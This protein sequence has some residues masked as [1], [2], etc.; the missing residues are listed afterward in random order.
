MGEHPGNGEEVFVDNCMDCHMLNGEGENIGPDLTGIASKGLRFIAESITVPTK[1]ITEG[2]E[3]WE[4]IRKDG[5]KFV[6]I[7]LRED[8]TEVELIRATG[9]IIV[10]ARA[11]IQT[12][13]QDESSSIM[14]A[15]LTEALT[16][17]D[18]QDVQAYLM[19]QKEQ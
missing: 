14:P 16:I 10:I 19:M 9:E 6:G 18:F 15:D 3:T 13:L 4:V 11:D 17:K 8:A 2:Y 12:M 5:R 7:K 1:S